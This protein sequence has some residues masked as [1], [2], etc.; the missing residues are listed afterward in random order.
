V[1]KGESNCD[2]ERISIVTHYM[3]IPPKNAIIVTT[4][5][6]HVERN[7]PSTWPVSFVES[8]EVGDVVGCI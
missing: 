5:Y 8:V 1:K 6:Y 4:M 7:F 2:F 3:H